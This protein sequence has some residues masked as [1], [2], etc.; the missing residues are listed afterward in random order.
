M[1]KKLFLLPLLALGALFGMS[2]VSNS[3]VAVRAEEVVE[4]EEPAFE[5]KTYTYVCDKGTITVILKSANEL[6]LIMT[7]NEGE[8]RQATCSYIRV[9]NVITM[10][11]FGQEFKIEVNDET[12]AFIEYVEEQAE[13]WQDK[14]NEFKETYL[15]PLLGGV[16]ITSV[17]SA[18]ISIV[19]AII[20]RK[21][22]G[23]IK[24]SNKETIDLSVSVL[25]SAAN[26]IDEM[27][28]FNSIS[29]E[30]RKQFKEATDNL[31][32]NVV[33]LSGKTEQM[34]KIKDC[35]NQLVLIEEKI[36]SHSKELVA[37]GVAED[38]HK[39]IEDVNNIK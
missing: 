19:L 20:N 37:S 36:A 12:L 7:S 17:V 8:V 4:V 21:T 28:E 18:L 26:L 6:E 16:S 5:E 10:D 2:C 35:V 24:E 38:I 22:N 13:D 15:A 30:T 25:K 3:P 39:L 34:L 31:L 29:E 32:K 23:K 9:G 11:L 14:L 27:K 33:E 1:K